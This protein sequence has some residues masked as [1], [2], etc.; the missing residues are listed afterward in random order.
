MPAGGG[1]GRP[2]G[3]EPAPPGGGKAN[4]SIPAGGPPP[5]CWKGG[6]GMLGGRPPGPGGMPWGPPGGKGMLGG[7]FGAVIVSVWYWGGWGASGTHTTSAAHEVWWH[8]TH[9]RHPWI[10]QQCTETIVG[11]MLWLW[12][13]TRRHKWRHPPHG[14]RH[15]HWGTRHAHGTTHGHWATWEAAC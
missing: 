4:G 9:W 14:W 15:A 8:S 1:K 2:P 6:G 13:R 11:G 5:M 3:G 10:S 7:M 12:C